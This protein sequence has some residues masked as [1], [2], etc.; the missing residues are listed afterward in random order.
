MKWNT[1][2][3]SYRTMVMRN[4]GQN[5]FIKLD[6]LM[7]GPVSKALGIPSYVKWGVQSGQTFAS[8][9]GDFMKPVV[10]FGNVLLTFQI[11]K[12]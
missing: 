3:I 5:R 11:R 8:L 12:N 2:D 10:H 9:S 4:F 6:K 7:R 1:T